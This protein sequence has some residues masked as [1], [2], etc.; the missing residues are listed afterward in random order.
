M[1]YEKDVQERKYWWCPK[2][3]WPFAVCSGIRTQHKW[4]YN[5]S[6]VKESD[7][8][9]VGMLEGC[10]NG[11][12][13]TWSKPVFNAGTKYY[14]AGEMC[15]DSSL[16]ADEGRCDPS[17]EGMLASG[18]SA[19]AP[20]ASPISEIET[21]GRT[22]V[23]ETGSFD[24]SGEHKRL[25]QDGVWPWSR[26]WHDQS[27]AA[28]VTTRFGN[29]QWYV[30]GVPISTSSGT[31]NVSAYCT[32]PFPLP[33]GRSENRTVKIRFTVQTGQ[34]SSTL[35]LQNDPA[36]GAYSIVIGM[37]ATDVDTG[38]QFASRTDSANFC[39]ETCDFDPA[40]E[41]ELIRC[42]TAF[43]DLNR[44]QPKPKLGP[45][46]PEPVFTI[47]DEI[48]RVTPREKKEVVASIL[49]VM[50]ATFQT[51]SVAFSHASMLLA[52]RVNVPDVSKFW[53]VRIAQADDAA[54][55]TGC[56]CGRNAIGVVALIGL[57]LVVWQLAKMKQSR[58]RS[59]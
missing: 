59:L 50:S 19:S 23:V 48:W 43:I 35:V 58:G 13:Y 3:Y 2:W 10:E 49:G 24:F 18:L 33:A 8:G 9:F 46:S 42:L 37:V 31:I 57:G 39:G 26:T 22:E 55:A 16:G 52:N 27:I 51:D 14:P 41:A 44:Q 32:W 45:P 12:L 1:P 38:Q 53:S 25:C 29:V 54:S 21:E 7:Y 28:S 6:W 47:N 4:C 11:K 36:D 34:D 40:K 20:Y 15:F 17:R 5:F 56:G 30:G